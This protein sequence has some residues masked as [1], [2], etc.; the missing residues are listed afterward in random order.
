MRLRWL[1]G[2]K[3]EAGK[4]IYLCG[5]ADLATE[6]FKKGLLDE[7]IL[8]L[9]PVLL[10]SG[11]PLLTAWADT[12][13]WSDSGARHTRAEWCCFHIG[14][15]SKVAKKMDVQMQ[16]VFP[17]LPVFLVSGWPCFLFF[18]RP[19]PRRASPHLTPM[20]LT[21]PCATRYRTQLFGA[22]DSLR[23]LLLPRAL[24]RQWSSF[25]LR[26]E[27]QNQQSYEID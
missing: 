2:L 1:G 8:K 16:R 14:S 18:A 11:I 26:R 5:G 3:A 19:Q 23:V 4:D 27:G 13:N 24:F 15:R 21:V 12:S 9:N 25:C 6:L 7:V 22:L 17:M 10:G 20:A